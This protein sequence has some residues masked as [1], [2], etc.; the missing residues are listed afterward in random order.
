MKN[1]KAQVG[2]SFFTIA[3]ENTVK[4][5]LEKKLYLSRRLNLGN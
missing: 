4:E 2:T 3:P 1:I 5:D